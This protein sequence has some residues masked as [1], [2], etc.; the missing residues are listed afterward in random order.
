MRILSEAA[1]EEILSAEL[2]V[3]VNEEAFLLLHKG[4]AKVPDRLIVS[5][6]EYEGVTLFKPCSV[7]DSIGAKVVSIRPGN[8]AK[9]L[10]TV[11]GMVFLLDAETALPTA[12]MGA[13]FLTGMR[14]AAGS[15]VATSV[16]A[17][18][19]ASVMTVFGAGLQA[20]LHVRAVSVVRTLSKVYIVNRTLANAETLCSSLSDTFP[21]VE[22]VAI[23]SA[24]LEEVE[25]SVRAAHIICTTTNATDALFDGNWVSPGCHINGIG[26]YTPAMT[27]VDINAVS[28]ARVVVDSEHA[29]DTCGDLLNA[30]NQGK[31]DRSSIRELGE[32]L[33]DNNKDSVR[34]SSE[35]ITFFKSVGTAVQDIV[36]ARAVLR[37]AVAKDI[38]V[39]V[40]M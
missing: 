40:E 35:A 5:S 29:I 21:S 22:F 15:A 14:T 30:I 27:E 2:A 24:S 23:A 28:R 36:T 26:S 19:D 37:E 20:R 17:L 1:V 38:G 32:V 33:S 12:L 31:L 6:P 25:A 18:K 7:P 11:P 8:A 16:M 4:E 10:P 3:K 39:V 9:K 34:T 13:S